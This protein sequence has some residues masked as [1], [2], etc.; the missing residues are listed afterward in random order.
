MKKNTV[1]VLAFIL[2]IMLIIPNF[3]Y[4]L[5]TD[6][7]KDIYKSEGTSRVTN[8]GSSILG[9]VQVV[10]ISV[11]VI[12]L[13]VLGIKYMWMSSNAGDKASIKEKLIPYV[14]GAIIMFGGSGLLGIIAKFAQNM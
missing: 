11:G 9:V 14:I 1:K 2:C 10:G 5:D 8:M 7:Y 12:M 3:V 6:S 4:A 13:I